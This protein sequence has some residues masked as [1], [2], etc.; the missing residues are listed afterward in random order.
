MKVLLLLDDVSS[1]DQLEALAGKHSWFGS[2][3]RILITTRDEHLLRTHKVGHIYLV[4][5][6]S[7]DEAI[8]LFKIHAYNEEVPVEDYETLSLRVVS[9]AAG[10]PLALK[11]LGSF[12]Y[13]KNNSEWIG[14][15]KKLKE[16]PDHEVMNILKISYDGLE[17]YQKEL[18][19]DIA[20][21][22]NKKSQHDAVEILEACGYHPGIGIKVLKQKA[23]ISI[24]NG[25]FDMHD[26]LQ[27]MGH[28]IV[29]G[30]GVHPYSPESYSRLW[31]E[32]DIK[33]LCLRDALK[34]NYKI[35]AIKYNG[36]LYDG[37]H[38]FSSRFFK[39]VSKLKKLRWLRVDMHTRMFDGEPTFLNELCYAD[40]Y[41]TSSFLNSYPLM[42]L[43]ILNLSW[44]T[45]QEVR[46]ENDTSRTLGPSLLQ[47]NDTIK[48]TTYKD[49]E[50]VLEFPR[51]SLSTLR[52]LKV[53]YSTLTELGKGRWK[54][55]PN[56]K[57]LHLSSMWKLL[58][59]PD[60]NALPCL[61]KLIISQCDE[62]VE[63]HSS[64]GRHGSLKYIS[65]S[66]CPELR[67]FPTIVHMENLKT[68]EI[69]YC[70]LEDGDIPSGIDRLSNLQELSLRGNKFSR[71]DFSLLQLTRIKL[72]NISGC[73][74][75]LELPQLP[76]GLV[77]LKA[78]SCKS[79]TT[80]GDCHKNC[81]QLRHVSLMDVI[82]NDA[83]RLLEFM[84]EVCLSISL[85]INL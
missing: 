18:F 35:E 20:C 53:H 11:V 71:L 72:L 65:V 55:L 21:F 85:N 82:I 38:D 60:F 49:F 2:G 76:P 78:D 24:V 39:I 77:I 46:K 17:T 44:S 62:L 34:E 48:A 80:T 73:E 37:G 43:I 81:K 9:Y 69:G 45:Y 15:L 70:N 58:N 74:Q 42:N 54:Q 51:L 26:L 84:L 7:D 57:T 13:D 23:L 6:L 75:L 14:T 22:W 1:V 3:S 36:Y 16:I 19:L 52:Y 27:E 47:E 25:N 68:V 8:R 4:K 12:L 66:Y 63:I 41:P 29:R 56:L 50:S 40:G 61:E 83:D 30:E 64:L 5:L 28:Y 33:N 59:T 10:L 32:E 31:K 67:I 79:V